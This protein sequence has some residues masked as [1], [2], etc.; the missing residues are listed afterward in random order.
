[1]CANLVS[2]TRS[3][4]PSKSGLIVCPS[5]LTVQDCLIHTHTESG[6]PGDSLRNRVHR[7]T[8]TLTTLVRAHPCDEQVVSNGVQCQVLPPSSIRL[9]P[10]ELRCI[11]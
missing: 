7:Y 5:S 1:M 8:H 2:S 4:L 10:H 11:K 9:A 3:H 6:D